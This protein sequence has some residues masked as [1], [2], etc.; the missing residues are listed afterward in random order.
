[1][2]KYLVRAHYCTWAGNPASCSR[3]IEAESHEA[4]LDAMGARVRGFK[5]FMGK[6]DM[7]CVKVSDKRNGRPYRGAPCAEVDI[8]Q[9]GS[10][11]TGTYGFPPLGPRTPGAGW[12]IP[13]QP[14]ER[15]ALAYARAHLAN[16]DGP[17][18]WR[19]LVAEFCSTLI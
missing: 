1:M 8:S 3:T 11:W 9:R 10:A 14:T 16:M 13:P 15:E 2:A 18:A 5:R 12:H 7:D 17:A 4:A 6:L 19:A